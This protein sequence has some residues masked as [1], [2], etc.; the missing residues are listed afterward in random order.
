[1]PHG[2]PTAWARGRALERAVADVFLA[3]G[4]DV[5]CNVVCTGGSGARHE[6]DVLAT[7]EDGAVATR[8]ALECK[9]WRAPV[10]TEVIARARLLRD[11]L[12]VDRVVVVAPGGWSP[13]A[14]RAADAHGVN[15]WGADD[16][17]ARLGRR[18]L[19]ALAPLPA[20][21]GDGLAR[22]VDHAAA[23]RH[24]RV[25]VAGAL[26]L[27]RERLEW[28][29]P[30]WLPVH[31]LTLACA[32]PAGRVR[33]RVRVAHVHVTVDAVA[34]S[35]LAAADAPLTTAPVA[36]D[37]PALP[38]EVRASALVQRLD[39][40]ARRS[41]GLVQPAARAR[42]VAELTRLGVPD[43]TEEVR[44]EA[45]RTLV[46]PVAVGLVRRRDGRRLAVLDAVTGR[47]DASLS[48]ALTPCLALVTA[49][50]TPAAPAPPG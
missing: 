24:L 43:G 30:A 15:L 45:V 13:A 8:V 41:A 7:R 11:E 21:V 14:G 4:W 42:A 32:A 22:R 18:A 31:E 34:G 36:L 26:G 40:L 12:G 9:H 3:E 23:A 1:M 46:V 20:P 16:L 39:A 37:A 19:G 6:V 47:V 49:A 33:R 48:D 25:H 28:A 5:A 17:A 50:L 29:V 38:D 35:V 44:V 2:A 27:G 10:G